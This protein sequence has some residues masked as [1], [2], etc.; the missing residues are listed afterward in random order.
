VE[1]VTS[2]AQNIVSAYGKGATLR[3]VGTSMADFK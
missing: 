3:D 1:L 2:S